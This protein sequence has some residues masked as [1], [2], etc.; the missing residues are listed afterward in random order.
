MV[1]YINTSGVAQ[2]ASPQDVIAMTQIGVPPTVI[3]AMHTPGTGLRLCGKKCL[4]IVIGQ[5][6]RAEW[7]RR[8]TKIG[9]SSL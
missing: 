3:Q 4:G 1:N 8:G 6:E 9:G 7:P 2:P 5:G